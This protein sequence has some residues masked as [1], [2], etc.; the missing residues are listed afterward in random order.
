MIS[1]TNKNKIVKSNEP[2][3]LMSDGEYTSFPLKYN[4]IQI[5]VQYDPHVCFEG[6]NHCWRELFVSCEECCNVSVGVGL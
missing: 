6:T 5:L 3:V 4:K 1:H 2:F